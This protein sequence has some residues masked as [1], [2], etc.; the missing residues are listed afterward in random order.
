MKQLTLFDDTEYQPRFQAFLDYMGAADH[1]EV[2]TREFIA[3]CSGHADQFK[4][5]KGIT[6]LHGYHEEFTDYLKEVK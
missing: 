5:G 6:R 3:W 1:T 2:N 4:R